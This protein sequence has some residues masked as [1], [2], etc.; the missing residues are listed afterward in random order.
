MT[1]LSDGRIRF[2]KKKDKTLPVK[3]VD[4]FTGCDRHHMGKKTHKKITQLNSTTS[5]FCSM[6]QCDEHTANAQIQSIDP[7]RR[8]LQDLLPR[9][10]RGH[11]QACSE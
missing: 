1:A 5:N 10:L 9:S 4:R 8:P 7:T 6:E 11:C 2:L 3:F